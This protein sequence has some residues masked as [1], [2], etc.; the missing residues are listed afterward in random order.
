MRKTIGAVGILLLAAATKLNAAPCSPAATTLCLNASRFQV[1]VDWRDSRGRTGT[2]Q[3]V[4]ITAD[5][6]YFWFFSASNIELIVKVLD[7]R[8]VNH[9][10]WV[11]FGALSNVEYDLTIT[12]TTTGAVKTY[13]NPLGQFASVAD[14]DAFENAPPAPIHETVTVTGSPAPPATLAAIQGFIEASVS[15]SV[16]AFTPCKSVASTLALNNCRFALT[17]DWADSRGRTGR[18]IPVQLTNDTGYFWFFSASNVELVIKVLDARS[19]NHNFW[20]FYGALSDVQYTLTVTDGLTGEV[21]VYRNPSGSLA[22]VG[23]TEAFHSGHSVVSTADGGRSVSATV[24]SEGGS[25]SADAADG[26]Q[27][28]LEFPPHALDRELAIRMTPLSRVDGLPFS[29]GLVGGVQ[30]EPDGLSLAV[31][32]TLTIRP[33]GGLRP[34]AVGFSYVGKGEEL[35]LD[36]SQLEAAEIRLQ[37]LHFSGY[38]AGNATPGD[39]GNQAAN[40]PAS[41]VQAIRQQIAEIVERG[42]SHEDEDGNVIPAELTEVEVI[43]YITQIID[44]AIYERVSPALDAVLP[45]CNREV[46]RATAKFALET[47]RGIQFLGIAEDQRIQVRLEGLIAQMI[48]ILE[49]CETKAHRDCV[50]YQDPFQAFTMVEIERQLQL[51]GVDTAGVLEPGG[52]IESCLRFEIQF[53]STVSMEIPPAGAAFRIPA[54][55]KAKLRIDP[56]NSIRDVSWKGTD[57]IRL[58]DTFIDPLDPADGHCSVSAYSATPSA[59]KVGDPIPANLI[60]LSTHL[61]EEESPGYFTSFD[62]SVGYDPGDPAFSYS[63]TCVDGHGRR[64]NFDFPA[65]DYPSIWLS[66]YLVN[67]IFDAKGEGVG[68]LAEGWDVYA[69]PGIYARKE[70]HVSSPLVSEDTTIL[71]THTP[72]AP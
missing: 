21:R 22:S 31:P 39:L 45:D 71:I 11:F 16:G 35:A 24:G 29:R 17:V 32:A 42:R 64:T 25:L 30:L 40:V 9:K 69:L 37:V 28:L 12:D 50:T 34:G 67:H 23:D 46:I 49:T 4:S 19:I 57:T 52:P 72:D 27:F 36:L 10:Y 55:A 44:D 51:F 6:G 8:S 68:F 1:D 20:V 63:L 60:P 26:T 3:A 56:E 7:A 5:T 54:S 47:I 48:H 59:F 70:Y 58:G 65:P 62:L 61:A 33:P 18:G 14:T 15:K 41:I 38:G 13:H 2:G 53:D 43:E 66:A